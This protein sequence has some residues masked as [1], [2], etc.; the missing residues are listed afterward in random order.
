MRLLAAIAAQIGALI[1]LFNTSSNLWL[2]LGYFGL[3]A[4]A[5]ALI[6]LIAAPLLPK[7]WRE[8]RWAGFAM[9]FSTAFF[10]PF[11]GLLIM[12]SY[13]LLVIWMPRYRT[14][15]KFAA[16][17][18]LQ[19]TTFRN[20]EG[21]AFRSGQVRGRLSDKSAA[22]DVRLQALTA[23]QD[24]P[25]RTTGEL[26][27]DLLAD[28]LEDL[29]LLAYGLLDGKEKAITQRITT[30]REALKK[31]D[32]ERDRS[33]VIATNKRIA[34]LYWELIY[35]HLVQGD[36]LTF[37]AQEAY[38]HAEAALLIDNQ[39][40]G[41]W[42]LLGRIGLARNDLQGA[43]EAFD[44][45]L[46]HGFPRERALPYLAELRYRQRKFS[47]VLM[48]VGELQQQRN[49]PMLEPVLRYWKSV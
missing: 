28:P 38:A 11:A 3:Q 7:Q 9:I 8:P 23:V 6:G 40:F 15:P 14:P 19:Y 26:L 36:L 43:S 37:T 49:A 4:I 39:D 48:V 46:T 2:L 35:Q 20:H 33:D 41:L 16:L 42:F 25:A 30:E 29:R 32:A 21:T 34:E 27:R 12:G 1:L 10:V 22:L 47:D 5:S 31:L 17:P 18:P 13:V 24:A 44:I 45:A